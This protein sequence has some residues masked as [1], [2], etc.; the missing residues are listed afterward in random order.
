[1]TIARKT[2]LFVAALFALL[3]AGSPA[4]VVAL[5]GGDGGAGLTC[6]WCVDVD[7]SPGMGSAVPVDPADHADPVP[8][9]SSPGPF[10]PTSVSLECTATTEQPRPTG[11]A[12]TDPLPDPCPGPE[13]H[14]FWDEVHRQV[15][16][17]C[18]TKDYVILETKCEA[19]GEVYVFRARVDCSGGS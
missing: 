3:V 15:E 10:S 1:M 2:Y 17:A 18:G 14:V 9:V 7:G 6:A 8:Q 13:E 4:E 5:D 12:S 11:P 19:V 16:E